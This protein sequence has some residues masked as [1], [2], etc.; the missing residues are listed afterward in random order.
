[1]Q[2]TRIVGSLRSDDFI[3]STRRGHVTAGCGWLPSS[4]L[5]RSVHADRNDKEPRCPAAVWL[6]PCSPL[7]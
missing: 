4:I 3:A 7:R 1:M 2:V 5:F 6:P